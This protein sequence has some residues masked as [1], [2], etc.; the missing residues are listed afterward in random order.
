[1]NKPKQILLFLV[2]LIGGLSSCQTASDIEDDSNV[3]V[4]WESNDLIRMHLHGMVDTLIEDGYTTSFNKD[5][6]R[7]DRFKANY[8]YNNV[9]KYVPSSAVSFRNHLTL[10]PSLSANK[11]NTNRSLFTM[12]DDTLMEVYNQIVDEYNKE[13]WRTTALSK[14]VFSGKYPKKITDGGYDNIYD[15]FVYSSNGMYRSF[16]DSHGKYTFLEDNEYL[17]LSS[18]VCNYQYT[19]YSHTASLTDTVN[20]SVNYSYNDRKDLLNVV[21]ND[22]ILGPN[23]AFEEYTD[24]QYDQQGNWISRKFKSKQV[25][26]NYIDS[27]TQTR[28]ITYY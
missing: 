21:R 3:S 8:E 22:S 26:S 1:M 10:I 9:G 5:G 2:L 24:Y 6:W 16:N 11:G 19:I 15:N 28:V 27:T 12:V 18:Y 17:R 25:D 13:I 4:Y 7:D 23:V 14:V 20:Y